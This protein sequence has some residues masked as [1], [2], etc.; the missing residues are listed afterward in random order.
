VPGGNGLGLRWRSDLPPA[1]ARAKRLASTSRE[2]PH[3]AT[4]VNESSAT[5]IIQK[6]EKGHYPQHR[7]H[8]MSMLCPQCG[9]IIVS[10][11]R[12]S[13]QGL[14]NTF[15]VWPRDVS[16]PVAEEVDER[17]RRDFKEAEAVL[18]QSAKASAALSRRMLQ[19][20]L[21]EKAKV[22]ESNL[23]NEIQEVMDSGKVPSW[24]A[25]NLDAVRVVGNFAAH[26]IKSTHS[27]EVVE[28][29]RGEA[30]FLLEVLEGLFDFYFVQPKRARQQRDAIKRE[31]SGSW[32][33]RT[34]SL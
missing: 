34:K 32:Q 28:V 2:C 16:R 1:P 15:L 5:T 8:D 14:S 29:E 17:Y 4:A 25:D 33:A 18:P 11:L 21:R 31:A 6:Q 27:G 12:L 3:C 20:I 24:L 9:E 7:W 23:N 30:E 13:P 22:T 10:L 26:P 19:D